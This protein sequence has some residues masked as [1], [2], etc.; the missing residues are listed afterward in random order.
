MAVAGRFAGVAE[1]DLDPALRADGALAA[2]SPA[3]VREDDRGA[4]GL[5]AARADEP[6]ASP[7][8]APLAAVAGRRRGAVP[9]E[10]DPRVLPGRTAP[11]NSRSS[12]SA[13]E[14][15]AR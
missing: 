12:V 13:P 6:R 4:A 5:P 2:P 8:A 9:G 10:R 7:R 14:T 11:A 3:E 1:I 15:A